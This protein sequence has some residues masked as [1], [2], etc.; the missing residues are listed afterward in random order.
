MP[1]VRKLVG[2]S[3]V[4]PLLIL[5][6]CIWRIFVPQLPANNGLGWD[7]YRY[8]LL[9]VDGLKS[10]VLDSYLVLRIFP[11]LLLH[12]LF[13]V[14]HIAFTPETV[15]LAFKIMSSVLIAISAWIVK[16]IFDQYKL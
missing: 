13:A 8:Y 9:T 16:R 4:I 1:F 3:Y 14:F 11:S 7:G 2:N 6:I 5:C 12:S 10:N 15:I